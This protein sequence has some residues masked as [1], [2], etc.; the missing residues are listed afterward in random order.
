MKKRKKTEEELRREVQR[1]I[2]DMYVAPELEEEPESEVHRIYREWWEKRSK[3]KPLITIEEMQEELD[4][5][6]EDMKNLDE[7][8]RTISVRRLL[9]FL[10]GL[11]GVAVFVAWKQPIGI[12][13]LLIAGFVYMLEVGYHSRNQGERKG[14]TCGIAL[15]RNYI[16]RL[17]GGWREF[18]ET[19]AEYVQEGNTVATDLHVL[20]RD[21][22][23]QRICVAHSER[24]KRRLAEVLQ[25]KEC[26]PEQIRER[27]KAVQFMV[28]DERFSTAFDFYGH[29]NEHVVPEKGPY[30]EGES[31]AEWKMPVGL[32]ILAVG[33]PVILGCLV[34]G[35]IFE[36]WNYVVPIILFLTGIGV[37]LLMTEYC[38]KKMQPLLYYEKVA[39]QIEAQI[40]ILANWKFPD[41]YLEDWRLRMMAGRN[42]REMI[43]QT[44]NITRLIEEYRVRQNPF[45]HWILCGLYLRDLWLMRKTVR[46]IR[47]YGS[48]FEIA[49][50]LIGEV[51]MLTSLAMVARLNPASF[52]T[53]LDRKEPE[54]QFTELGH[55]LISREQ[56]VTNSI[57][58]KQQTVIVTG[59]NMSGKTTFLRTIG[60]NMVLAYAGAPICAKAGSVSIMK[61]FTS[62]G[63]TDDMQEGISTFYAEILR[64][65]E[66]VEYGK[67]HR[68]ML[69]LI[70][71]IFRGTNSTDRI[72][73]AEE[74]IRRLTN[75]DTITMVSTHDFELCR[76]AEN[77]HFEESY[78]NDRIC[79]DYKLK[80]GMCHTTNAMYLLKMAGLVDEFGQNA[81]K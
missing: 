36:L 49:L 57:A 19:G 63:I 60:L 71:E 52:P 1:M 74:V 40:C 5:R 24:G 9:A 61:L 81:Q 77:Y 4:W 46:W 42:A 75:S 59:S 76:L 33:Y 13:V 58:L 78:E 35:S 16:K 10:V 67:E 64:I 7:S 41:G 11:V 43:E 37:S 27:Q 20:G 23:Y 25:G 15:Y 53:I 18:S 17:D 2:D 55:P 30:A 12:L 62:M 39:M 32:Q 31:A 21:S 66:M 72:T 28:A 73:G 50:D 6:E 29:L 22:L 54:L 80:Q 3:Y 8:D 14:H 48:T 38:K 45:L 56:A 69:C 79:F 68:P 70:D 47:E 34:L 26:T 51:E 44:K 65:R